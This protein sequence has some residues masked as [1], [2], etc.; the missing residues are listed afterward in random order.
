[1]ISGLPY[2]SDSDFVLGLEKVIDSGVNHISLYSL[3]VEE[4][5]LLE[6]Q[7]SR[8]EV[9]YSDEVNE[10]QWILGR[11]FLENQGFYQYEVSNFAKPGFESR[12]NTV[13]WHVENYLGCGAGATGTVDDFR[14]N[15]NADVEKY[16]DFWLGDDFDLSSIPCDVE[17][18]TE[19]EKEFEFLMMGFR[20]REGVKASEYKKRFGGDLASRLGYSKTTKNLENPGHFDK[21]MQKNLADVEILSNSEDLRFFLTSSGI[22]F[23]NQFLEE[24]M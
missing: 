20:L 8:E 16:I 21:W 12:H 24:L 19:A 14:W 15:N 2:L 23:L 5:T 7:I 6:K 1:L 3:M 13:Y 17:N 10:N 22:M 9:D 18:L 4:G 11:D